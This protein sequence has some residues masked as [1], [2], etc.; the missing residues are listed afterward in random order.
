L[1]LIN[2]LN[3]KITNAQLQNATAHFTKC[4]ISTVSVLMHTG[5]RNINAET[6]DEGEYK[7]KVRV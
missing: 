6:N 3:V 4:V 7:L 1:S 2:L 5:Q